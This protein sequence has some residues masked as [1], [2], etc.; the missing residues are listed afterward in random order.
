MP[1]KCENS[2]FI[3]SIQETNIGKTMAAM[4]CER[5]KKRKEDAAK[6]NE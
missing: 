4:D 1:E 5:G 6:G 3:E 2:P